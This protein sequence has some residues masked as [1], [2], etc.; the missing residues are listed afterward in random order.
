MNLNGKWIGFD[1]NSGKD[2]EIIIEGEHITWTEYSRKTNEP[3]KQNGSFKLVANGR[4]PAMEDCFD[5]VIT[6]DTGWAS[7]PEYICHSENTEGKRIS[8]I[9]EMT[10]IYDG[11]GL[12]VAREYVLSDCMEFIT[13]DFMSRLRLLCN[14]K[15]SVPMAQTLAVGGDGTTEWTC[16]CGNSKNTGRFCTECGSPRPV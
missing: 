6:R 8:I 16:S 12:V 11:P 7:V 2:D 14:N 5:I 1:R 13:K 15:T 4:F 10:M 9:S 3:V